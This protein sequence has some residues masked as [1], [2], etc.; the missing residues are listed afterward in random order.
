MEQGKWRTFL[1][2]IAP[3]YFCILHQITFS[4]IT[5]PA[6]IFIRKNISQER[7][8]CCFFPPLLS[9]SFLPVKNS[10]IGWCVVLV[11]HKYKLRRNGSASARVGGAILCAQ[12]APLGASSLHRGWENRA[13]EYGGKAQTGTSPEPGSQCLEQKPGRDHTAMWH[14]LGIGTQAHAGDVWCLPPPATVVQA[15]HSSG[16]SGQSP[17]SPLPKGIQTQDKICKSKHIYHPFTSRTLPLLWVPQ[18]PT[19]KNNQRLC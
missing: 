15:Q 9:Q 6:R 16:I 18:H 4:I 5:L 10:H 19:K 1:F 3:S 17:V 7:W 2:T 12:Q 11:I 13:D 14:K 8:D